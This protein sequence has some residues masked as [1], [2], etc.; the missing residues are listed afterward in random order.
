MTTWKDL[1]GM[2]FPHILEC[3]FFFFFFLKFSDMYLRDSVRMMF[4]KYHTGMAFLYVLE[5]IIFCLLT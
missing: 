3:T 1:I 2:T 5:Y 4:E